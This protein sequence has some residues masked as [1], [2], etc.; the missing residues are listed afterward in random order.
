MLGYNGEKIIS[1]I[2]QCLFEV[3]PGDGHRYRLRLYFVHWLR[4]NDICCVPDAVSS[5]PQTLLLGLFR[6]VVEHCLSKFLAASRFYNSGALRDCYVQYDSISSK[7][8]EKVEN[9]S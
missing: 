8:V 1:K 4:Q 2:V 7:K 3:P 5:S 9:T 6:G